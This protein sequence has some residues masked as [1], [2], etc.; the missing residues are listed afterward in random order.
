MLPPP[1]PTITNGTY[2]STSTT[3]DAQIILEVNRLSGPI[4]QSFTDL[5]GLNILN[6]NVFQCNYAI[7]GST[8]LPRQDPASGTYI[9]GS[10]EFNR[11]MIVIAVVIAIFASGASFVFLVTRY[12]N[13]NGQKW[14][15]VVGQM[16]NEFI[17]FRDFVR[18]VS[19]AL[20]DNYDEN[21]VPKKLCHL[22]RFIDILTTIRQVV[23][24]ATAFS[25]LTCLPCYISF[26]LFTDTFSTHKDKYG[27]ITT[28]AFLTG[29]LPAATFIALWNCATITTLVVI[30][31]KYGMKASTTQSIYNYC[32]KGSSFVPFSK[33]KTEEQQGVEETELDNNVA[34]RPSCA[35]SMN[36]TVD[37]RDVAMP[38]IKKHMRKYAYIS[39]VF[40][41]NGML[42]FLLNSLYVAALASNRISLAAKMLSQVVMAFVKLFLNMVVV[43]S[44]VAKIT[45]GKSKAKLHTLMLIVNTLVA[46]CLATA[47]ADSSCFSELFTG[48]G[49][50]CSSYSFR[51]C[52]EAD[53]EL[54]DSVYKTVCSHY[55]TPSF[56]VEF[57]PAFTYNYSCGA[58]I[59]M[60]YIPVFIYSYVMLAVGAPLLYYLLSIVPARF[61]PSI[62]LRNIDCVLRPQDFHTFSSEKDQPK[63][64]PARSF[65][66]SGSIQALFIQHICILLTFGM[67][68][69]LLSCAICFAM[70]INSSMWQYIIFR[71]MRHTYESL[72]TDSSA[73][74]SPSADD[75]AFSPLLTE[76]ASYV[77]RYD[78][79]VEGCSP[80]PEDKRTNPPTFLDKIDPD[81][82]LFVE[83]DAACEDTW[84][85][86]KFCMWLLFYCCCAF[87]G[88][89]VFDIVGDSHG[90]STALSVPII[91]CGFVL[92]VR[93]FL[94]EVVN[95]FQSS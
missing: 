22:F 5:F 50:I 28:S 16:R 40:V 6:G 71:Y 86:L 66:Q 77:E 51:A 10:D 95:K 7:G 54:V 30:I 1:T 45:F 90:I 83:L 35:S 80:A 85:S 74:L 17:S 9:C 39:A 13:A 82:I 68:S 92:A 11:A 4:P 18:D 62:L 29:D 26:Y 75:N 25:V 73:G 23:V 59:L 56:V 12:I 70:V 89:I 44:L 46:P 36:V 41:F 72:S 20:N 38:D 42:S 24:Y 32:M 57:S 2:S 91:L 78:I 3:Q 31:Q 65:I 58:E 79:T 60:A 8:G 19:A 67:N 37:T 27:W 76:R 63:A 15:K 87:Y 21:L 52:L 69:P 61:I 94:V 93:F 55:E 33:A 48:S 49:M 34:L 14:R 53:Q 64:P 88:F 84:H 81:Y 43:K 47:L